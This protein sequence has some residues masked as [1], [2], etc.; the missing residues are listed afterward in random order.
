MLQSDYSD[1]GIK[2]D[3]VDIVAIAISR[4]ASALMM[5]QPNADATVPFTPL[6]QLLKKNDF[7][8]INPLHDTISSVVIF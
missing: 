6:F 4:K 2:Q 3:D 8:F 7:R 5:G 1:M